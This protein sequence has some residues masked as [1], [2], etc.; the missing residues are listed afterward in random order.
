MFSFSSLACTV[1]CCRPM[2]NGERK[3]SSTHERTR[4]RK[5]RKVYPV[6]FLEGYR[7]HL[8]SEL[9]C[10]CYCCCIPF[11]PTTQLKT[12]QGVPSS[13]RWLL[14]LCFYCILLDFD[15]PTLLY[16][17]LRDCFCRCTFY[18]V[19]CF[20][21]FCLRA[22]CFSFSWRIC[23]S[24]RLG[25]WCIPVS[26]SLFLRGPLS[27]RSSLSRKQ[28]PFCILS[29]VTSVYTFF[30]VLKQAL[31]HATIPTTDDVHFL[32]QLLFFLLQ[33]R[34]FSRRPD[35]LFSIYV[36]LIGWDWLF[37]SLFCTGF[38]CFLFLIG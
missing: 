15:E 12:T 16:S 17:I 5:S 10:Y 28:Q 13:Q 19:F 7:K 21:L 38:F 4:T 35:S 22:S 37:F 2:Q 11:A 27:W 25:W 33:L 3:Q 31:T 6:R 32:L 18:L 20:K 8:A 23:I 24:T 36:G 9:A 14:F 26:V 30:Q 1:S 34:F 29:T